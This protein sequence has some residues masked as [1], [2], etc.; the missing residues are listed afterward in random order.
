MLRF[1]PLAVFFAV[2]L[3]V[4]TPQS[5]QASCGDWLQHAA[6][7]ADTDTMGADRTPPPMAPC[8][9]P[10]C[11]QSPRDPGPLPASPSVDRHHHDAAWLRQAGVAADLLDAEWFVADRL[12]LPDGYR[13]G[14]ERPPQS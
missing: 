8:H 5:V 12:F 2:L 3:G 1:F 14:I 7:P 4:C 10:Q 9:G 11:R 13:M 6:S